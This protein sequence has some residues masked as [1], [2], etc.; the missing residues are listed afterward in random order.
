[1]NEGKVGGRKVKQPLKCENI[2]WEKKN[3]IPFSILFLV[4]TV[5][6]HER[7]PTFTSKTL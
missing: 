5:N 3:Q 4:K 6:L 7:P 1:M 2:K